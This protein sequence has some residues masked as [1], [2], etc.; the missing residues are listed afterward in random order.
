MVL[1]SGVTEN[2]SGG[3]SIRLIWNSIICLTVLFTSSTQCQIQLNRA[4]YAVEAVADVR[5]L[6]GKQIQ[7][8]GQYLQ[9]IGG[10][11]E[12]QQLGTFHRPLQCGDTGTVKLFFLFTTL[13]VRKGGIDFRSGIEQHLLESEFGFLLAGF[14]NGKLCA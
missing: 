5:Q 3:C 7:L 11:V 4:L 2:T 13:D 10:S 9:V 6:C 12:H 8:G 14:G 1:L